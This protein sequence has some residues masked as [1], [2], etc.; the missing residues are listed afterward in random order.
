MNERLKIMRKALGLKQRELADVI[1]VKENTVAIW[2]S[3]SKSPS[4]RAIRDICREF[5]INEAWLRTGEGEMMVP[6]SKSEQIAKFI[7]TASEDEHSFQSRLIH[8]LA[9]LNQ[10]Q[11]DVLETIADDLASQKKSNP[12]PQEGVD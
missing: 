11:W 3:G 5:A 1:G 8:T 7:T 4:S 12:L 2:E 6:K 9:H 10:E